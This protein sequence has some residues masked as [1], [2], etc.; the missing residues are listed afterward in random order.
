MNNITSAP[1]DLK[2]TQPIRLSDVPRLDSAAAKE[3]DFVGVY[4]WT[5]TP[6][7]RPDEE[8]L[9]YVGRATR[10][11]GVLKRWRDHFINQVS[12]R[13]IIPPAF[14]GPS[15]PTEWSL[16][17]A[18]PA[19]TEHLT[20]A[21]RFS[22]VVR[23]GFAVAAAS[24]MS[25]ARVEVPGVRVQDVERQLLW[26]LRPRDNIWGCNSPPSTSLRFKHV[27]ATWANSYVKRQILAALR[28]TSWGGT[29][30]DLRDLG[31]S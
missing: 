31:F 7:G 12:G 3:L 15:I 1:M 24:K 9:A 28:G 19:V 14:R 26:E 16:N 22:E 6:P 23:Q 11:T 30:V 20:S 25:A 4:V 21:D 29:A 13:Y 17:W 18:E 5:I 27:E 10:S 2:W 8:Y